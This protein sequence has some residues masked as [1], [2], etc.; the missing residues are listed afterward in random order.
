M[1]R[2][3][4]NCKT[5]LDQKRL[6][7]RHNSILLHL[8]KQLTASGCKKRITAY[9]AGYELPSGGTVPPEVLVT[10]ARPDL[11]LIDSDAKSIELY[12]LTSCADKAENIRKARERKILRYS[13]LVVVT[14]KLQAGRPA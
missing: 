11:V 10:N 6:D 5:A 9:V 13:S 3:L 4:T 7:F 8:A 12:E 2:V 1:L 14:S